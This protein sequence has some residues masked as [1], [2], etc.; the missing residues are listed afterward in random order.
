MSQAGPGA[1]FMKYETQ[2]EEKGI[3][4]SEQ[5]AKIWN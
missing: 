3:L 5:R 2:F 4:S 1:G